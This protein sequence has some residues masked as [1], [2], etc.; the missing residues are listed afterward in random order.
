MAFSSYWGSRVAQA[1][2]GQSVLPVITGVYVKL[3]TGNPGAACT[4]NVSAE[5]TRK[6]LAF[7]AESGGVV[8]ATSVTWASWPAPA[9]GETISHV[10]FWDALT[11]GNAL[12]YAATGASKTMATG[13]PYILSSASITAVES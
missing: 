10:S 9:N 1:T 12:S 5:T 13:D 4:A 3:H 2:V 8:T 6:V 7:A 11:A